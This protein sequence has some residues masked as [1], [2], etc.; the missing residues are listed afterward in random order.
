MGD[1][2]RAWRI[3]LGA[4]AIGLAWVLRDIVVLVALALLF[5]AALTPAIA[6]MERWG[7]PRSLGVSVAM[8]ALLGSLVGFGLYVAPLVADQASEFAR[9]LP[10]LTEQVSRLEDR[11]A[12]WHGAMPFVPRFQEV[13]GWLTGQIETLAR[14]VLDITGRF[15]GLVVAGITVLFLMVFILLDGRRLGEQ[16]LALVPVEARDRTRTVLGTM[17]R[18]VG[19]YMLGR[20]AVM[21]AVGVATGIGLTLLGVPYAVVLGLVAGLLDIVPYIGPIL[22]AVPGVLVGLGTSFEMGVWVAL[23]YWAVPLGSL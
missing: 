12:G 7:L 8:L 22:A 18:H 19:H 20:L 5:S 23:M 2:S 21:A 16:L 17:Y 6:A 15:V 3:G 9:A 10:A 14:S 11:W 13:T 1:G 4:L